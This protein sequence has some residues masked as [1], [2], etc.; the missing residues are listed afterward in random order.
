MSKIYVNESITII[1]TGIEVKA[2]NALMRDS[3]T[4]DQNAIVRD[5]TRDAYIF[6]WNKIYRLIHTAPPRNFGPV[7]LK[8][9]MN[10]I[11]TYNLVEDKERALLE[12][13]SIYECNHG[14]VKVPAFQCAFC[15][16]LI[17]QPTTEPIIF[18]DDIANAIIKE[19]GISKRTKSRFI[20]AMQMYFDE[21]TLKIKE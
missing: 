1:P 12:P 5:D 14:W 11:N 6:D 17:L 18:N 15:H 7:A 19:L 8:A 20:L 4:W 13:Q 10:W 16:A 9:V 3:N 2:F 21:L